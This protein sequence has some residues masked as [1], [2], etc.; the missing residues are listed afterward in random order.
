MLTRPLPITPRPAVAADSRVLSKIVLAPDHGPTTLVGFLEKADIKHGGQYLINLK[1]IFIFS[2]ST[3]LD[4]EMHFQTMLNI[5]ILLK[6]SCGD[7]HPL[8]K[9][10][11][12]PH[13]LFCPEILLSGWYNISRV[14]L[15]SNGSIELSPT[16]N[17]HFKLLEK[18][19]T[20]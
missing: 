4:P 19:K 7:S 15:Y 18:V 1:N 10:V 3:G 20:K 14:N 11:S 13:G 8:P 16:I 5:E 12:L 2:G 17:T 9:I 6:I